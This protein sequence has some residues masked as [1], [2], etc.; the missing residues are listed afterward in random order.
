M[1]RA[2]PA[3][4][5]NAAN[6]PPRTARVVANDESAINMRR[7]SCRAL[8]ER[9]AHRSRFSTVPAELRPVA[10]TMKLDDC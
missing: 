5:L 10:T 3:D 6:P 7:V 9:A 1:S 8:P 4:C 2:V